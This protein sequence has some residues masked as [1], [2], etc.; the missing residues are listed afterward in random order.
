M[1]D[2]LLFLKN[3]F[4]YSCNPQNKICELVVDKVSVPE[5]SPSIATEAYRI[6]D[7]RS[8]RLVELRDTV[9]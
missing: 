4:L 1:Y 9:T 8:Q 3:L 5:A 6:V 2:F 7:Y